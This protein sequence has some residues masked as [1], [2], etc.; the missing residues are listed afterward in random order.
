MPLLPE[1]NKDMGF[2]LVLFFL[3]EN[4]VGA[5]GYLQR[6]RMLLYET[7]DVANTLLFQNLIHGYENTR[8]LYITETIV[9]GGAEKLH[10]FT[11]M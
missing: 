9:D 3:I 2:L 8:L 11:F 5:T 10:R 1:S 6:L 4:L 7:V